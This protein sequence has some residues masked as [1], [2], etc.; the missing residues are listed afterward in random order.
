MQPRRHLLRVPRMVELQQPAEDLTPGE[1]VDGEAHTLG[2]LVEAMAQA[3]LS[4][5]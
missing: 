3:R 5:P 4:Q 1:V 2:N